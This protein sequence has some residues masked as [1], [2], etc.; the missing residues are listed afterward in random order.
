MPVPKRRHQRESPSGEPIRPEDSPEPKRHQRETTSPGSLVT[1]DQPSTAVTSDPPFT[2]PVPP[3]VVRSEHSRR[4]YQE[5]S[6]NG[7]ITREAPPSGE[8]SPPPAQGIGRHAPLGNNHQ[9]RDGTPTEPRRNR[10]ED[11]ETVS[12]ASP[13][14]STGCLSPYPPPPARPP[15]PPPPAEPTNLRGHPLPREGSSSQSPLPGPP[16]TPSP[17]EDFA[18]WGG[19]S[20]AEIRRQKS[21]LEALERRRRASLSPSPGPLS[22]SMISP[23]TSPPPSPPLVASR[24]NRLGPP[25]LPPGSSPINQPDHRSSHPAPMYSP[26]LSTPPPGIPRLGAP[27]LPSSLQ[28]REILAG[29]QQPRSRHTIRSETVSAS[30]STRHSERAG[31]LEGARPRRGAMSIHFDDSEIAEPEAQRLFAAMR[32]SPNQA[33]ID[34]IRDLETARTTGTSLFQ[35]GLRNTP[36]DSTSDDSIGSLQ[37]S[38]QQTTTKSASSDHK[39]GFVTSCKG[40]QRQDCDRS[41]ASTEERSKIQHIRRLRELHDPH[42]MAHS[43]SSPSAQDP[44]F[45]FSASKGYYEAVVP[46]AYA[47]NNPNTRP[48]STTDPFFQC[49]PSDPD[50]IPFLRG[51]R[52]A[53]RPPTPEIHLDETPQQK[54]EHLKQ[55]KKAQRKEDWTL[56]KDVSLSRSWHLQ[57]SARSRTVVSREH[58]LSSLSGGSSISLGSPTDEAEFQAHLAKIK[59]EY[60]KRTR[61][62]ELEGEAADSMVG[63]IPIS[64]LAID[65]SISSRSRR[66]AQPEEAQPL[67]VGREP[68][69]VHEPSS[70]AGPSS[71]RNIPDAGEPSQGK[72]KES[73][74][75][76]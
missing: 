25:P 75:R 67:E 16:V 4:T 73:R 35:Q 28:T 62:L 71:S 32:G 21:M 15:P 26:A 76:K 63:Y 14:G 47:M 74:R 46:I 64:E 20:E 39:K 8:G 1:Q 12:S 65:P 22:P 43:R 49:F 56:R 19:L 53:T 7:R 30:S 42:G 60:Y 58:I 17:V 57:Y 10:I 13:D 18:L 3:Q 37:R 55:V 45:R 69:H 38:I 41:P 6:S 2:S 70:E 40:K 24:P 61:A 44:T 68:E 54:K 5:M 59:K 72:K 48:L 31:S 50:E 36:F 34:L 33:S 23:L 9:L 66:T 29:P 27:P 11:M 51:T 52:L